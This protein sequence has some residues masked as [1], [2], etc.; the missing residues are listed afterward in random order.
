LTAPPGE[1]RL[2][3]DRQSLPAGFEIWGSTEVTEGGDAAQRDVEL[4]RSATLSPRLVIHA[5][6]TISGRTSVACA[7]RVSV[8]FD[9]SGAAK[10][11]GYPARSVE[12]SAD[13]SFVIRN[14][15]EGSVTLTAGGKPS[16]LDLPAG[17]ATV[18]D[19]RLEARCDSPRFGHSSTR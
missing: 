4:S 3:I 8:R 6:R 19:L 11:P 7:T 10:T 17:P 13:G 18:Q 15:P 1:W 12:T 14:L 9:S 16:K 5:M 2:A